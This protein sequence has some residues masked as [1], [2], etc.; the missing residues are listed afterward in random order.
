[1]LR[2]FLM[3]TL[4][5]IIVGLVV[6]AGASLIFRS[7]GSM[8]VDIGVG[9]AGAFVGG[10]IFRV[11]GLHTQCGGFAGTIVVG[12]AGAVVLLGGLH[13]FRRVRPKV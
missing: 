12:F 10:F 11:T 2:R 7:A 5:L 4:I 3:D 13:L 8:L 1:V 6:G 9:V